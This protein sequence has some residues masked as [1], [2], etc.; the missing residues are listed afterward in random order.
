MLQNSRLLLALV[1]VASGAAV[2]A[3][4]S[5]STSGGAGSA[6][7]DA[8]GGGGGGGFGTGGGEGGS[9][10]LPCH[11][12]STNAEIAG[13]NCDDDGDGMVDNV[14]VC[15]S[16]LSATGDAAAFAH[17]MGICDDASAKGFGLVSATFTRG[18][19]STDTPQDAQHSIMS[20]FGDV[21][22]PHEGS[23]LGVI[24]SGYALEFD[25]PS[26]VG[27]FN[28]GK[29]WYGYGTGNTGKPGNG[30]AP[31]GFPKKSAG[32]AQ[33]ATVNDTVDVKL[34]LKV[35][36]NA[37]GFKFDLDFWS[38][39]WPAYVCSPFNDAFIAFLTSQGT[40]DNISFD[41]KGNPISVNAGFL[42]RCST[43]GTAVGAV[44]CAKG[45]DAIPGMA[46]CSAGADELKGTGFFNQG[47]W[48][49]TD[50]ATGGA[51]T[52]WLTSSASVNP[53]ETITLELMVWDAGDGVL[54]STTLLDNFRWTPDP[55]GTG[56]SVAV[57]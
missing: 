26:G 51:S 20:K 11:P 6:Q 24:S 56:T 12:S 52:G 8:G 44:G 21:I 45:A 1:L 40:T 57:K 4:S 36:P 38:G 35:P 49:G 27:T 14:P 30:K 31:P 23:M 39:E 42:D 2:G 34:T 28:S 33:N 37:H 3:C 25:G 15:D 53:G 48:C 18:Y 13:N 41:P 50:T 7:T 5:D 10:T 47:M 19:Q 43:T 29:D 22:K 9:S 32:C 55:V 16:G 46:S 54:D 17:A